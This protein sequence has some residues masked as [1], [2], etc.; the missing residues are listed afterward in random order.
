[1][2]VSVGGMRLATGWRVRGSIPGG[3]DIFRARPDRPLGS[4]R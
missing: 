1:M 3:G 2:Q 4:W